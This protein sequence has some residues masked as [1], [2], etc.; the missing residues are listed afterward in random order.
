MSTPLGGDPV[1]AGLLAA[2]PRI[3]KELPGWAEGHLL[4]A[5]AAFHD[6]ATDAQMATALANL[7]EVLRQRADVDRWLGEI[8]N[9]GTGEYAGDLRMW[10]S[11]SQYR[12]RI[13]LANEPITNRTQIIDQAHQLRESLL[14]PLTKEESPNLR[15]PPSRPDA[16]S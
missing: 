2:V 4:P 11:P 6:D 7:C 12:E 3:R 13:P 14:P 5:L 16:K 8:A 1:L 10:P 15:V 9:R